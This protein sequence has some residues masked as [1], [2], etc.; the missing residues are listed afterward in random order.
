[1]NTAILA[2]VVVP[3][4]LALLLAALTLVSYRADPPSARRRGE[5]RRQQELLDR[6]IELRGEVPDELWPHVTPASKPERRQEI[7]AVR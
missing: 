7:A 3:F 2:I 4:T 5:S 1:M 6:A